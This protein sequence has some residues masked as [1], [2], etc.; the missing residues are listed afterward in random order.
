MEYLIGFVVVTVL[1][2]SLDTYVWWRRNKAV[3]DD[4]NNTSR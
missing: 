1:Y 2:L 4:N 3:K